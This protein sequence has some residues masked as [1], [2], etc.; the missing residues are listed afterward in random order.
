MERDKIKA[1]YDAVIE[2]I[3]SH[4]GSGFELLEDLAGSIMSSL[5]RL[6]IDG[7]WRVRVDKHSP[8]TA[9]PVDTASIEL[10]D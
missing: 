10:E 9:L 3:A 4:Q 5:H 7:R 2:A 1:D 6:D 8:P